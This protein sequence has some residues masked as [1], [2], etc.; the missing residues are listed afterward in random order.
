[1][2][3]AEIERQTRDKNLVIALLHFFQLPLPPFNCK[4]LDPTHVELAR[5][6]E[7]IFKVCTYVRHLL[8]DAHYLTLPEAPADLAG[9]FLRPRDEDA[10]LA[11]VRSLAA[12]PRFYP[13]M[14]R[15]FAL[16]IEAEWRSGGAA[17]QVEVSVRAEAVEAVEAPASPANSPLDTLLTQRAPS[18]VF[19]ASGNAQ[20][21]INIGHAFPS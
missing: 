5:P 1:M 13:L 11:R 14:R 21:T 19:Q 20:Q 4:R 7:V 10:A 6:L 18:F 16:Q 8:R 17:G 2:E 9:L 3:L 15:S 12:P